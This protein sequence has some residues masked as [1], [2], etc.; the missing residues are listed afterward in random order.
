MEYSEEGTYFF[1]P[2]DFIDQDDV[3]ELRD[4][5][6]V[7]ENKWMSALKN[8]LLEMQG[9]Q[10]ILFVANSKI[11]NVTSMTHPGGRRLSRNRG[12]AGKNTVMLQ[13]LFKAQ[14]NKA[15]QTGAVYILIS[16]FP[17]YFS[18]EKVF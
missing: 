17:D 6:K 15:I 1:N 12:K 4:K 13:A 3:D 8:H 14:Q 5:L 9:S 7:E 11:I 10:Q 16:F 2:D 18:T